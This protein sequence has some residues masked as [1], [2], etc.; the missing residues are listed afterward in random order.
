[1]NNLKREDI[2]IT[3]KIRNDNYGVEKTRKSVIGSLKH[4][5]VDY[6]DL[7]LLHHAKAGFLEPSDPKNKDMRR[8]TWIEVEKL[9]GWLAE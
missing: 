5:K 6:V 3:T 4:L 8:E 1:M 2:F 7:L 9:K